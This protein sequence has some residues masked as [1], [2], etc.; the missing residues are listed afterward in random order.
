L[1]IPNI[2]SSY[3]NALDTDTNLYLVHDSLRVK[4]AEDYTPGDTNIIVYDEDNVMSYFPP[5][6]IIT[7]TEQCS[8]I[9]DRAISL[10]YGS[11]TSTTFTDL[12]ALPNFPVVSKPKDFTNV[13]L[14]VIAQH[15]NAIKNAIIAIQEF[16]GVKG[17]TDTV[18]FGA[19]IEGR[20][21]FLTK[22]V[23]TPKAWFTSNKVMGLVPLDITFTDESF[24]LGNGDVV[25]TWNFGDY[26]T[27]N[28]SISWQ[29]ISVT[30]FRTV[31]H[32][33]YSPGYYNVTLTVSN[34][35]GTDTIVLP[36]FINA[37]IPAPDEAVI[38]FVPT[39]GQ[40]TTSGVPSGGP[41][42]TPPTIRSPMDTL[43]SVEIPSGINPSTGR[44]YA[45]EEMIGSN[46]RD[47]IDEY[48]WSLGD[49]LTHSNQDNAKGLYSIGGIYDIILRVDTDFG[50]Y[51]ITKYSD[52]IDVVENQN[53]WL[54][55]FPTAD[56]VGN[57]SP[58]DY[59]TKNGLATAHEFGLL[60]ETFKTATHTVNIN[61]D[62][63]F[64]TGTANEYQ[65]KT[66]FR[67]NV[68]FC[69]RGTTDS[70]SGGTSL[71]YWAGQGSAL[72]IP[73]VYTDHEI[74]VS[75][76]NG[77]EDTYTSHTA[78]K[79]PWNWVNL[80]SN[81]H[82]YFILGADYTSGSIP[83]H[84]YSYQV[85]S[86]YD[87]LTLTNVNTAIALSDYTN[88]AQ[89]LQEHIEIYDPITG[90][91]TYGHFAAY[92][93]TW[94]D[95]SGYFLRN[96]AVGSFFRIKSFYKTEGILTNEFQTIAKLTDMAGPVKVEGQLVALSD[97]LFFFNNTGNISAFNTT[98]N[99]WETGGAVASSASFRS[100]QDSTIIG[101]DDPVNTLLATTNGDRTAY[102]SYDYSQYAFIKFS[103]LDLTFSNIGP[104]PG[105]YTRKNT[106]FLIGMY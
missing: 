17:T 76:Y 64:L 42:I 100:L 86:T 105:W 10:H 62:E 33:Y 57:Y 40:I 80:N 72:P 26:T 54:W 46:P 12:E 55:T 99:T 20:L 82:S 50:A 90:D 18:P 102:L 25:Y 15:H 74:K 49:D 28:I 16:V 85:K 93:A 83:F 96:D 98:S 44:S 71:I 97:G 63:S 79:R 48:T 75:E 6:G 2:I 52:S 22:L 39:V 78:I 91:S 3:S 88:G 29:D 51:R 59:L 21:N 31:S 36:S 27:S 73:G 23:F 81:T 89:D 67:R 56:P 24:R 30:H 58:L 13:T 66:E 4:L 70:G 34:T 1:T 38:D 43:I 84:S 14:N 53:I 103:S 104:R 60:S 95:N 37:R 69:P 92:R 7:L 61:R 94:K 77:F 11:K 65:A 9:D 87:L 47:P 45:G 35:Y 41:Y 32:I 5:T 106:Q 101:F 8:D 19:T 68:G